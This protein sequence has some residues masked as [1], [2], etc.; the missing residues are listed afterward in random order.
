[1]EI[2]KHK[3]FEGSCEMDMDRHVCRGK[4]LFIKDLVTYEADSPAELRQAFQ[5]AVEDYLETCAELG[6]DPAKPMSGQFNVRIDPELH[7]RLALAGIARERSLNAMVGHAIQCYLDS[8]SEINHHH[9]VSLTFQSITVDA[10]FG[11]DMLISS[12]ASMSDRNDVQH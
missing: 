3:G 5:D 2:M 12:S 8:A 4:I 10:S 6:R 7:R 11:E 9:H 1:M